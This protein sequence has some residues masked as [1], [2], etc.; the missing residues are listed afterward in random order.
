MPPI[1][2]SEYER[3]M[4]KPWEPFNR[5]SPA[6]KPS[7]TEEAL[8]R[9]IEIL[10]KIEASRTEKR[11]LNELSNEDVQKVTKE[12]DEVYNEMRKLT[13]KCEVLENAL[14][15][16]KDEVNKEFDKQNPF[17]AAE[18]R[19]LHQALEM[20]KQS[21]YA[22][23]IRTRLRIPDLSAQDLSK[24]NMEELEKQVLQMIADDK[25][26]KPLI[27]GDRDIDMGT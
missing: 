26:Q 24:I 14:K 19:R 12:L 25:I 11:K 5:P 4:G 6:D 23:G 1:S 8:K 27:Y 9:K 13:L 7:E 18:L 10:Q 20:A 22:R 2:R 3:R 17:N 21:K 15:N 16:F